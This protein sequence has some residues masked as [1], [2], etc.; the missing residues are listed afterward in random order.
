MV[1]ITGGLTQTTLLLITLSDLAFYN[2]TEG[3]ML[4]QYGSTYH[5]KKIYIYLLIVKYLHSHLYQNY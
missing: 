1:Q 2:K 3:I 5:K 4:S